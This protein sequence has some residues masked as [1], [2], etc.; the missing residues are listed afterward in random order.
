MFKWA[1]DYME[2]TTSLEVCAEDSY[3]PEPSP[4]I[5]A[6]SYYALKKKEEGSGKKTTDNIK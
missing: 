3:Q 1:I 5:Y 2:F 4:E 6:T